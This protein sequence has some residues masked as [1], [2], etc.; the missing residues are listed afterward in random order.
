VLYCAA[1]ERTRVPVYS[2][3]RLSTYEKCPLQYRFRYLDRIKRDV[4]SIEAFM[5][6]RVHEA[7]EKLY[8]D[9]MMSRCPSL[10][11]LVALYQRSWRENFSDRIKIVKTEYTA[12]HYRQ[13]GERCLVGYYRRYEPFDDGQTLGLEDRI[14]LSLDPAGRYQLQGYIDRLVRSGGG[15][16]EI[17]DYKTGG[18]LP[19]DADLRKDRQL[20][21][22]QMAV[23]K[24]FPDAHDIRLVWHYLA[25]DQ[26]LTSART[27]EEVEQHRRQTIGLI[28]SIEE[29]KAFPPRESALCRWCEY[30]DICPVQKHLVKVEALEPNQYLNDDGVRLVDRLAEFLTRKRSVEKEIAKVEEAILA[31]S[32]R[33][34]ATVLRGTGHTARV[35][36]G[37]PGE[38]RIALSL[39]KPEQINLFE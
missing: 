13:V 9:L 35:Q 24:R 21:L 22:Y 11:E 8:R 26:K 16:Y 19:S 37:D 6:N 38:P 23:Q 29:T 17:H 39:Y 20:T 10:D 18:S 4:Q 36:A 1:D 14:Q 25:F 28:D 15:V 2:H 30:R 5:G 3:S 33:E 31:Y 34:K 7:L 27:P 32:G 12:E